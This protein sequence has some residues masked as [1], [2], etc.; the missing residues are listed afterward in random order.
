MASTS[1]RIAEARL[2]LKNQVT[3]PEPIIDELGV[4]PNDTLVFE[5][6]PDR[7]GTATIR[8]LPDT[9]AGALTGIYGSA[10]EV[11]AFLREE[12]A[13]WEE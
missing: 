5:A 6:D 7:P 12:H 1:R 2:R 11:K 9:F 8:R 10:D 4:E 3:V 13:G